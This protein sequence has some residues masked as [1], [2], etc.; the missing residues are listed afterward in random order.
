MPWTVQ[1]GQTTLAV[2]F[3]VIPHET[4][5]RIEYSKH[6]VPEGGLCDDASAGAT[7]VAVAPQ[8]IYLTA[9]SEGTGEV[10]LVVSDTG[11]V[12]E[13]VDV[14]IT[15]AGP[16]GR[17]SPSSIAISVSPNR[18]TVGGETTVRVDLELDASREYVLTTVLLNRPN[19]AF[20]R[21]CSDFEETDNI[22]GS[23]SV[24]Y[25]Y[26]AYG[27]AIPGAGVWAYTTVGGRPWSSAMLSDSIAISEPMP[28]TPVPP[29]PVP[30]DPTPPGRVPTP[31]G[32]GGDRSLTASWSAPDDDGG[33]T[34]T[35]YEV[36]YKVTTATSW[37]SAGSVSGTTKTITGLTNGTYYHVQAR[38]CNAPGDAGCGL[39]SY[40]ATIEVS[41][42][43]P[44]PTPPGRVPTPTGTGYNGS[45][46][47][48][49]SA[50]DDDGG[51][52]ITSYDVRYKVSTASSWTSAGSVS[53]RSKTITG[54]A[55]GTTYH[56]QARACNVAGCG[57]WSYSA[58]GK[59]RTTPNRVSTP[60]VTA[61][62]G[63]LTATWSAPYDG[64]ATTTSYDV[65][66]KVTTATSWTSAGSVSGTTK[67]ITGLTNGTTYHVQ[68]RACNVAGCGAWSYSAIGKP[69][70]TPNRVS[71]PTVT[72]GDS[73]LKVDWSQPYNGGATIIRYEV[74]YKVTTASSWTGAGSVSFATE[75]TISRLAN[76]TTYHV[77]ARACNVAGC[78]LWSGSATGMPRTTPDRVSTP[79][80]TAGDS[81]LKVD[82]SQPY[83]G[84]ATITRYE[85][86]YKVAIATPW[87]GAGSV[88]F[89]TEKTI[90]RLANGTTYHVQAR[91][92]NVAGCGLWS[93]SATG[94]PREKLAK[95]SGLHVKPLSLRRAQLTWAPSANAD[96]N[97]VYDVHAEA[98][99]G[100][101]SVI[102]NDLASATDGHVIDLDDIV[103]SKGLGHENYFKLW[104][105]AK[106][107]ARVKSDSEDSKKIRIIDNP[108][109]IEK[110]RA[111]GSRDDRAVLVWKRI[112]NV[113]YYIVEYRQLGNRGR[114]WPLPGYT[115]A[116]TS[117]PANENW[118]YYSDFFPNPQTIPQPSRGDT[119]P[120]TVLGLDRGKLYAFQVNYVTSGGE[121]VFSARDAFVWP[122]SER[123]PRRSR[124][125]TYPFFGYWEGGRYNYTVCSDTFD[126]PDT[127][128]DE[129]S[130]WT[131]LIGHAFEQWEQAVP[132]RVTVTRVFE[133]CTVDGVDIDN[134]VPFT[135]IGA[136][137]NKSNEV[138]MVDT[139]SWYSAILPLI[140]D[141]KLFLC[142]EVAPAC[143]LSTRYTDVDWR[144]PF[145]T[146]R[147]K[148]LE[149]GSV[150]VLVNAS[151][152]ASDKDIPG[153]D[154]IVHSGDTRFNTCRIETQDNDFYNYE[155]MVHEAGHALGLSGYE[156]LLSWVSHKPAHPSIP[157]SVMNYNSKVSRA[158]VPQD[159]GEPDC[160]P[161][162]FDIMAI[163]ALYQ[164]VT[165]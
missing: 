115:H 162:P 5:V 144:W 128:D 156:P 87:T 141:N 11:N 127:P 111:Y 142:I 164:T 138:Y 148:A 21:G 66:Y 58:I 39:W 7:P 74:R 4:E 33:A 85:V 165:P 23:A 34:I 60:T 159:F 48:S 163:E 126:K 104:V 10:R 117:W 38:A 150:D 78:G 133:S 161:H 143:V 65:Q 22:Q 83:N 54:L 64:G 6:F 52:T 76:G 68:A 70:T 154:E 119:I 118:P 14:S 1:V 55:N 147:V 123:P 77:Q 17:Q 13:E 29:T 137:F 30:P 155:L 49:W 18:I 88:S 19:A 107:K 43:L 36:R 63:S 26:T 130:E 109:L 102:A 146:P 124:I 67:T 91:A 158:I 51:A 82:W 46:T 61:G 37:T 62:D 145:T 106:D 114:W 100:A 112:A 27:C 108:L 44:D 125:A 101:S 99:T 25:S 9:C 47:A 97:T 89:A 57:A 42:P 160:S 35:S 79:T 81:S 69:R 132:D 75:K 31:T 16:T 149:D 110:G 2:G 8:W 12:I 92:C 105:V 72:A 86:R 28:P 140:S 151:R 84:G 98:P 139:S 50:P 103:N 116:D 71:T 122:S 96:A 45:L 15:P 94:M 90:S 32:T 73:S 20:D 131:A 40:S 120:A 24:R 157:D 136:L 56:V 135:L 121:K 113:D 3:H 80:V 129:S 152:H 59:P 41:P 134:D 93:G 53:S 95:P 153:N